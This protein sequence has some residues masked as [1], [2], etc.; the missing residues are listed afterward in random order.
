[1]DT[2]LAVDVP[3]LVL[4]GGIDAQTPTYWSEIVAGSPPNARLVVLPGGTHVQLG[5]VNLCAA[6]IL[7]SFLADPVACGRPPLRLSG[8]ASAPRRPGRSLRT[9]GAGAG[10]RM[11]RRP[12]APARTS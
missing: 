4:S 10:A 3:T 9:G 1:M 2:D 12:A 7:T 8:T 11:S 5:A 6:R